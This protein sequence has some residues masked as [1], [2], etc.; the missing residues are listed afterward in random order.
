M[1][2]IRSRVHRAD[3]CNL[4]MTNARIGIPIARDVEMSIDRRYIDAQIR[5]DKLIARIPTSAKV[6]IGSLLRVSL[7]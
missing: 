6:C 4:E 3:C 2:R 1:N 5:T 7:R